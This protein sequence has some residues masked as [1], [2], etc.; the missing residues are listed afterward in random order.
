MDNGVQD[1]IVYH[2]RSIFNRKFHRLIVKGTSYV[3]I[4]PFY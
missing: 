4:D 1:A 3:S 2:S